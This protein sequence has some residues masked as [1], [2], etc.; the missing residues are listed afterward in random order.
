MSNITLF[1]LGEEYFKTLRK[2][3]D[4]GGELTE[5]LE[6]ELNEKMDSVIRKQDGYLAV[7]EQYDSEIA[8]VDEWM[9][10]LKNKKASIVAQQDRLRKRLQEFMEFT[11][12]DT[13]EGTL[14]KVKLMSSLKIPDWVTPDK[15]SEEYK[16]IDF[17]VSLNKRDLLNDIKE[18]K[19][20]DIPLEETKYIKI[21]KPRKTKE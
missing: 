1:D 21:F 8:K 19:V 6:K 12:I 7:M 10:R 20:V 18:G 16:K 4:N 11:G 14:G 2:L 9:D 13:L 17:V 15:V 3:E 5:E